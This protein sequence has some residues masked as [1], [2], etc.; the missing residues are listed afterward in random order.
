[1][2]PRAVSALAAAILLTACGGG[3]AALSSDPSGPLPR[4]T[5]GPVEQIAVLEA[6]HQQGSIT[7]ARTPPAGGNHAPVW[8]NCGA[9]DVAVP[10]EMAVHSQEH[11]AV[12]I[13]YHPNLAPTD[14]EALRQLAR[15]QTY[16]I[17]SPFP[18]LPAPVVASAWG[19][20]QRY[21]TASDPALRE[22]IRMFRAGPQTPEPGAPCTGGAG[23]PR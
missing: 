14:A 7:Y 13:T 18:D 10:T 8:L 1:M 20:Q 4:A 15:S 19:R 16:V 5:T 23:Q 11:G 9:Y 2:S 6:T 12:W 3:T 21:A 22:F 17:V